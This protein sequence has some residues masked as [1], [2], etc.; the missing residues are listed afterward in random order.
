VVTRKTA[1]LGAGEKE[2][3]KLLQ[4][5]DSQ[6][7]QT[8]QH[9]GRL[10]GVPEVDGGITCWQNAR[11][12]ARRKGGERAWERHVRR[13]MRA[14]TYGCCFYSLSIFKSTPTSNREGM[15]RK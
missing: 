8:G 1:G 7:Q 11:S 15:S 9:P 14:H 2:S 13:A 5:G 12:K 3:S 6:Q 10:G 4:L